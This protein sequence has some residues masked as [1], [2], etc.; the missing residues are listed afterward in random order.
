MKDRLLNLLRLFLIVVICF[1]G[2]MIFRYYKANND[3]EKAN[4]D[5]K[6]VV[7]NIDDK[8]EKDLKVSKKEKDAK[9]ASVDKNAVEDDATKKKILELQ[10]SF[11]SVVATLKVDGTKI[12]LPVVQGKDNDFY[13]NHD[14]KGEYNPF[15]AVFMDYRNN[16][17]F[18]DMNTVLYGHNAKTGHVFYELEKFLDKEFSS[19]FGKIYLDTVEGRL[20]YNVVAVYV[21]SPYDDYRSPHYDESRWN[22]FIDWIN[23]KNVLDNRLD[24]NVDGFLTL[25]TCS[26]QSGRLVIHAVKEN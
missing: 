15:G 4:D 20:T 6:K 12:E 10:K 3:Y 13:L 24:A 11:P 23:K 21:A 9:K 16:T 2:F 18:D 25:S 1:C 8:I 7:S 19:K 26:G 5:Y 22:D 14:F 17:D